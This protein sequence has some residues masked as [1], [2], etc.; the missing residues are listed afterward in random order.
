[1][2]KYYVWTEFVDAAVPVFGCSVIVIKDIT[3]IVKLESKIL[4]IWHAQIEFKV[5]FS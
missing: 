1:M 5:G 2:H 4:L 3:K